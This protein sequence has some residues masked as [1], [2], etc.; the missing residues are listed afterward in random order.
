MIPGPELRARFP[1]ASG[2][3][4][5][6]ISV[7]DSGVGM[8][9]AT[10]SRIFEP[11]FT[12]KEFGRGTGL[13]LS[14]VYGIAKQMGGSIAVYS[15]LGQGST[16]RVFFPET[17]DGTGV[18]SPDT[19]AIESASGSETVLLVEDEDAVRGLVASVLRR[20]GYKVLVAA[21]PQAALALAAGESGPIHLVV[22]DMI[23]PGGTGPELV[24]DLLGAYPGLRTLYISGY[25]ESAL[26]HRGGLNIA[27]RFLQKPFT[28][29][30][31]L[32]RVRQVLVQPP[33]PQDEARSVI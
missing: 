17:A 32:E 14:T 23:M 6:A 19:T 20:H 10:R 18:A 8:D 15:E 13:G 22:T 30:Q 16:F 31:L 7:R 11:F 12:T 28:G 9:D 27:G 26:S 5:V 4:F 21:N 1:E 24:T 3:Q 33:G 29:P 25:A 2:E